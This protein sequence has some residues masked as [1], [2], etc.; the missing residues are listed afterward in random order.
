[1]TFRG[2]C[3][4]DDIEEFFLKEWLRQGGDRTFAES[5]FKSACVTATLTEF[6]KDRLARL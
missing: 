6:R 2:R 1:M 4:V 3:P 5:Q